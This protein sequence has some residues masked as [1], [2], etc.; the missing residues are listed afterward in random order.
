MLS[1]KRVTSRLRHL[2]IDETQRQVEVWRNALRERPLQH[3]DHSNW[4]NVPMPDF[5]GDLLYYSISPWLAIAVNRMA[6]IAM[7]SVPQVRHRD[8]SVSEVRDHPLLDLIG[9][10]GQPNDYQDS[11]EFR[12]TH[13]MHLDLFGNSFWYLASRSGG[14]PDEVYLLDPQR[15]FIKPG[16]NRTIDNYLYRHGGKDFRIDPVEIIQFRRAHPYAGGGYY[17]LSPSRVLRLDMTSDRNMSLWQRQFF[18][19]GVPSGIIVV[20]AS[21]T[22]EQVRTMAD[23]LELAHKDKR[24]VAIIRA[25][26]GSAVWY[27]AGLKQRDLDFERG[28]LLYRQAIFDMMGFH[29]GLVSEASTEAHARVAER[30]V[31]A[32]VW[33]RLSRTASRLTTSD[34]LGFWPGSSRFMVAFEDIRQADWEQEALKLSAMQPYLSEEEVRLREFGLGPRK[35]KVAQNGIGTDQSFDKGHDLVAGATDSAVGATDRGA[36]TTG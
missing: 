24:R 12:E 16:R 22:D 4:L 23:D 34:V 32:S 11:L 35:E 7:M 3:I 27:D 6:E 1:I 2:F 18:E 15:V 36:G 21:L 29:V 33:T 26:P 14:A 9:M 5:Q 25:E 13:F 30:R 8:D 28:R 19:S 10:H 31:L 17:G 20:P